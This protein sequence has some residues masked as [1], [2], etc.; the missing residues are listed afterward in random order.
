M[1]PNGVDT[2]YWF[3][4]GTDSSLNGASQTPLTAQDIGSGTAASSVNASV[5]GLNSGTLY[6]YRVM[7]SNSLGTTKGTVL[8]FLTSGTAKP[9]PTVLV[10]PSPISINTTQTA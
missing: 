10:T 9:T 6:Y 7:A 1:N 3:L 4:Y 5:A 8:N 2:H